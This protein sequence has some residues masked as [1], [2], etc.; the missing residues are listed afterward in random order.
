MRVRAPRKETRTILQVQDTCLAHVLQFRARRANLRLFV[1]RVRTRSPSK[2]RERTLANL[3]IRRDGWARCPQWVVMGGRLKKRKKSEE[4]D[5]EK[6]SKNARR[7]SNLARLAVRFAC[8][9]VGSRAKREFIQPTL[10]MSRCA[11]KS[12]ISTF[13]F[14]VNRHTE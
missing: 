11:H 2:D 9:R 6:G 12:F 5:D 1:T 10:S 8:L 14:I 7:E 4:N 13:E 3:A